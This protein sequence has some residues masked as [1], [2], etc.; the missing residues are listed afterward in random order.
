MLAHRLQRIGIEESVALERHPTDKSVIK[1]ALQNIVVLRIS[2]EQEQ[3]VVNIHITDGGTRLT[4]GTHIWQFIILAKSL[5]IRGGADTTGDIE[6]LCDDVVPDSID[7]LDIVLVASKCSHISHTGI[8][9]SSTD[10]MTYG[11][12]LLNN[13]LMSL[14][15]VVHNCG[16][17]TI[18]EE[19]LGLVEV[20]LIASNQIEFGKSH[21]CYLM[22]GHYT[23]LTRI[24]TN[25][26]AYDIGIAD[27]DIEELS[28][29]CSL[30]MGDGSLYHVTE[31][32]EFMAQVF[33]LT[34][35]FVAS[36]LMWL[37]RILGAGSVE[38]SVRLLSGSYYI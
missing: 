9:I 20:F 11:L 22:T 14:R 19:E 7:G 29:S 2:M 10:G 37:L 8:H 32:I 15:V 1:C 21:L 31:V 6:F 4:V 35:A 17:A 13:G 3:S 16:L 12:I 33:L 28:A 36:P 38:I 5:A 27:S 25:L 18:V 26:L 34:P 24:R 23:R 30:I